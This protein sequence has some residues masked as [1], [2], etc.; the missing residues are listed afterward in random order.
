[1]KC[2][3][4]LKLTKYTNSNIWILKKKRNI[5]MPHLCS[6]L[7]ECWLCTD[8]LYYCY[9]GKCKRWGIQ[10]L[11]LLAKYLKLVFFA[12]SSKL[13]FIA[14]SLKLVL[15]AIFLKLVLFAKYLKLVFFATSLKLVLFATSLKLVLFATL[16]KKQ[17]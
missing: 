8:A 7:G 12:T 10:L 15:F 3:S 5:H 1:M 17:K 2:H 11:V 4:Y 13:V 6:S 9:Q 14:T 16:G